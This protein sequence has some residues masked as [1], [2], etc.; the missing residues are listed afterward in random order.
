MWKYLYLTTLL[1]SS[2][3]ACAKL[4]LKSDRSKADGR[5]GNDSGNNTPGSIDSFDSEGKGTSPSGSQ[6]DPNIAPVTPKG[7]LGRMVVIADS[8]GTGLLADTNLTTGEESV[9]YV[10]R[11]YGNKITSLLSDLTKEKEP[12]KGDLKSFYLPGSSGYASTE[13]DWSFPRELEKLGYSFDEVVNKSEAGLTAYSGKG[14]VDKIEAEEASSYDTVFVALGHNDVCGEASV[15]DL[16]NNYRAF[17][18]V[19][20]EKFSQARFVVTLPANISGIMD[21]DLTIPVDIP[22]IGFDISC[23]SV[24]RAYCPAMAGT[25]ASVN[26]KVTALRE[27]IQNLSQ[28]LLSERGVSVLSS[29]EKDQIEATDLSIDCFHPSEEGQKKIA[30]VLAEEFSRNPPEL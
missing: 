2:V 11:E 30:K 14:F 10:L 6:A 9:R 25:I 18:E 19:S 29:L 15:E 8:I 4:E 12:S 24:R 13:V 1:L 27:G 17:L 20:L 3:M 28:E 26:N 23:S 7:S 21:H 5:A 22:L 16:L